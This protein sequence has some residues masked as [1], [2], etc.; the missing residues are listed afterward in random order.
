MLQPQCQKD[1]LIQFSCDSHFHALKQVVASNCLFSARLLQFCQ[2]DP[3]SLGIS[4]PACIWEAVSL[5]R[6]LIFPRLS[7]LS[8]YAEGF[9]LHSQSRALNSK[10]C[11][12]PGGPSPPPTKR[13]IH[14]TLGK[15]KTSG[16]PAG[17]GSRDQTPSAPVST[18]G[19]ELSQAA[20]PPSPCPVMLST[21]KPHCLNEIASGF[22]QLLVCRDGAI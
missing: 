14:L 11:C 22:Q 21:M 15:T 10:R 20:V 1:S 8:Q 12:L 13:K 3:P 16:F 4:L 17:K 2:K 18:E 7:T 5:S 9:H 6:L 19:S